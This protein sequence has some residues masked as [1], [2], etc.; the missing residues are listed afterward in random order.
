MFFKKIVGFS[1][2]LAAGV[3]SAHFSG[4]DPDSKRRQKPFEGTDVG[5]YKLVWS[6]EFNGSS[7]DEER[8]HYRLD[9]KHWSKQE[10]KNN[11][12]EGGLYRIL[13]QKET[14][15]CTNALKPG[16]TQQ[17]ASVVHYTGGGI[18]SNDYF[19]YGYYEARLRVPS[20]KGW[21]SSFWMMRDGVSAN[22]ESIVEL[23][24]F[25][26]DSIDHQ[27]FQIDAH[28]WRPKAGTEDPGRT[29]NKVGT[30]QVR[31]DDDTS[32][33]DFHVVGM[34]WTEDTVR[35]FFDGKLMAETPFSKARYKHNSLNIWFTSIG[36]WLG[37]TDAIDDSR[38]PEQMQVDYVRFFE[39]KR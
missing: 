32:L 21:H 1:L 33:N 13:L 10:K 2:F 9:C 5:G 27:H 31:F 30:T 4:V 24:P 3:V 18:I 7:V 12:V 22:Q 39:K 8:W 36:T 17:P 16:Q 19:Q 15:P 20:G 35:Y 11:I 28:Q 6:D 29:Q 14:V 25:E 38:L 37:N 23:D 34:E 26:N